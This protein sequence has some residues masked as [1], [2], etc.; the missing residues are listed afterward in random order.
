MACLASPSSKDLKYE[1]FEMSG[2]SELST[3]ALNWSEKL[4]HCNT[5]PENVGK[6]NFGNF[7]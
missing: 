4:C 1:N 6:D 7:S 2:R 5:S 3:V